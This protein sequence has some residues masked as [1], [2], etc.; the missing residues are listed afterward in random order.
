MDE[1]FRKLFMQNISIVYIGTK[2]V[3]KDTVANTGKIFD[4]MV[5]Q[6]VP[7]EPALMMLR[8][9]SVWRREADI[10]D[11]LKEQVTEN[12]DAALALAEQKA[13]ASSDIDLDDLLGGSLGNS[14][15]GDGPELSEI[16]EKLNTHAALDKFVDDN[17]LDLEAHRDLKVPARKALI[18]Q[19][20]SA[21]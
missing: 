13:A 5:P 6:L 19:Q 7:Y 21:A 16:L 1:L 4:R 8:H 3:K 15:E 12:V 18:E 10:T 20:A 9:P 11:E 14:G 2:P 17:G